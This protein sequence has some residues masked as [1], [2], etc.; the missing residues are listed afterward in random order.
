MSAFDEEAQEDLEESLQRKQ[1]ELDQVPEIVRQMRHLQIDFKAIRLYFK[2]LKQAT[3]NDAVYRKSITELTELIM[4]QYSCS[5]SPEM[6][7]MCT[8]GLLML[9]HIEEIGEFDWFQVSFEILSS[10]QEVYASVTTPQVR[11]E[12]QL[13]NHDLIV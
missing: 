11:K 10:L 8:R 2:L 12:H 6:R 4:H 3:K 7:L 1:S 13:V 9:L 5:D